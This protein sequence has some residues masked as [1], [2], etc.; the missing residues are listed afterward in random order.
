MDSIGMLDLDFVSFPLLHYLISTLIRNIVLI[1][2]LWSV[3]V[4]VS[5]QS[6][7][8]WNYERCLFCE[9]AFN[10]ITAHAG[11]S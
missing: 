9:Q 7:L 3:I 1:L 6:L 4:T 8:V 2:M 5:E 10:Q 11:R